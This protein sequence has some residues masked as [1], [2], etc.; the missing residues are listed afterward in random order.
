MLGTAELRTF[1]RHTLSPN[2]GSAAAAKRLVRPSRK[3]RNGALR[4]LPNG[5]S[6]WAIAVTPLVHD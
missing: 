2:A 3:Q 1:A 6:G 5:Q 4:I